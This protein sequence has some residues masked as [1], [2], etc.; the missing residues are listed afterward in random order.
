MNCTKVHISLQTLHR[1]EIQKDGK[2][3]VVGAPGNILYVKKYI[4][5]KTVRRKGIILAINIFSPLII[6]LSAP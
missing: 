5:P 1:Q 4:I 2:Q 3:K 6:I